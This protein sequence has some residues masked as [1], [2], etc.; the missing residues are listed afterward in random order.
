MPHIRHARFWT[1]FLLGS[2]AALLIMLTWQVVTPRVALAQVPDSGA[3]RNEM[4]TE[5]KITNQK[6]TEVA[7]LLREIRDLQAKD[8]GQEKKPAPRPAAQP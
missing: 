6:L 3:Q 4:I 2:L 7:G 8:K 5:Q 1:P